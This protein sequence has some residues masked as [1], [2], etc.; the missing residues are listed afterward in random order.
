MI[1][2]ATKSRTG[3]SRCASPDSR[4]TSS[5]TYDIRSTRSGSNGRW[6]EKPITRR[7]LSFGV[8]RDNAEDRLG[9][10]NSGCRQSAVG[11]VAAAVARSATG[12]F[13]GEA[14]PGAEAIL[15]RAGNTVGVPSQPLAGHQAK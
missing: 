7:G 5:N 10:L 11:A 8:Q 2:F 3:S 9:L 14:D 13:Y 1:A 4:L 15:R 12:S 6:P